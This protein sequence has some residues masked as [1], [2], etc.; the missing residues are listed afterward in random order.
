MLQDQELT[1]LAFTAAA[2]RLPAGAL[3]RVEVE[4]YLNAVDEE[5]V[6][7]TVVLANDEERIF[8]SPAVADV[9]FDVGEKIAEAGEERMPSFIFTTE[10]ELAHSGDPDT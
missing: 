10:D 5:G 8:S 7:F 3:R 9:I 6:R 4:P 1:R 2:A